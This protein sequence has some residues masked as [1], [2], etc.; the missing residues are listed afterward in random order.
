MKGAGSAL[1]FGR[2]HN[3]PIVER[4]PARCLVLALQSSRKR[5]R[6]TGTLAFVATLARC[7]DSPRSQRLTTG[8]AWRA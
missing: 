2:D 5:F 8:A 3:C 6:E 1:S 4:S 7:Y